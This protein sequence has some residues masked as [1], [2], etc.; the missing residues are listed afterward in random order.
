MDIVANLFIRMD[1][2]NPNMDPTNGNTNGGGTPCS[3]SQE[4]LI[5]ALAATIVVFA[6]FAVVFI[7]VGVLV[8]KPKPGAANKGGYITMVVLGSLA[9][10]YAFGALVGGIPVAVIAKRDC[11]SV[12]N[13]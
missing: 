8:V 5:S 13:S 3:N 10:A 11:V 6:V 4:L 9:A 1:P 12:V 7:T 2:F